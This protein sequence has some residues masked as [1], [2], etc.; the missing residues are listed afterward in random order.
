MLNVVYSYTVKVEG[1][2]LNFAGFVVSAW[3][4]AG[5]VLLLALL[6]VMIIRSRSRRSGKQPPPLPPR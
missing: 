5:S 1:L 6:I 3:I 4:I 2:K